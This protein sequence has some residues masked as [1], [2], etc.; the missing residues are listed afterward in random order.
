MGEGVT[1]QRGRRFANAGDAVIRRIGQIHC[2]E[3]LRRSVVPLCGGCL[4][5]ILTLRY[6]GL[7]WSDW[8][9]GVGAVVLWLV[10]ASVW[11]WWRRPTRFAA[12][13]LWDERA[14][15]GEAFA[16]AEF[17]E[18]KLERSEGEQLHLR[19][20]ERLLDVDVAAMRRDLPLPRMA[21][22]W[23][24]PL[25]LLAFSCSGLLKPQL[26]VDERRLGAVVAETAR[27]E[28]DLLRKEIDAMEKVGGLDAAEQ[29][30]YDEMVKAAKG[31]AT[32]ELQEA[33]DQSSR[34]LLSELE[35]RAHEAEKL[36]KQLGGEDDHWAS[37]EMLAAMRVHADTAD[38][39][40]ALR[41]KQAVRSANEAR[42]LAD[43]LGAEPLTNEIQGRIE[44]ALAESAA[45]ADEKDLT[46]PV[47]KHVTAA[48]QKMAVKQPEGAAEE[49]EKLAQEFDSKAQRER[50]KQQMQE[51][52][53][54]L[55]DVGSKIAGKNLS[56]MQQLAGSPREGLEPQELPMGFD[57]NQLMQM[58]PL[59]KSQ[60]MAMQNLPMMPTPP[61]M[62]PGKPGSAKPLA[63]APVPGMGAGKG[64]VPGLGSKPGEGAGA[65]V[66]PVPG[67]APGLGAGLGVGAGAV[68]G[69]LQA[70]SGTSDLGKA[71][72][73][74]QAAALNSTVTTAINADG[75]VSMRAVEG[76]VRG[77]AAEREASAERAEFVTIQEEALD[78]ATLPSSRR[79]HVKR[80]FDLLRRQFEAGEAGD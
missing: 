58:Q 53:Q 16:S 55:R 11:A 29:Q 36:A 1:R 27:A 34:E 43:R 19:R 25:L 26:G 48:S 75:E 63:M 50:A 76:E 77:E 72:T 62:K 5:V 47:G 4:L 7:R 70:G 31:M 49:L 9:A 8:Q 15:R 2:F 41:G 6:I 74:A 24:L 33:G 30:R 69:G 78:E 66:V 79:A 28:A 57:Q 71:P 80:Y 22:Q 52:A 23:M 38:L 32:K 51:L 44:R 59:G 68:P 56:G 39:S 12:L 54:R 37:E 3:F 60:A 42:A 73:E 10:L 21:W 61:G 17:F 65:G 35:E 45:K 13:A 18:S 40:D 20:S 46:K 64:V 67:M 14:G